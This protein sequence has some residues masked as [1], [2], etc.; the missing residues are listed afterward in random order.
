MTNIE[1][2]TALHELY[3]CVSHDANPAL[4]NP[5]WVERA[6]TAIEMATA[7]LEKQTTIAVYDEEELHHGCTVQVL[8][9]ST[10][11]EC[12]VGWWREE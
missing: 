12:S 1:A 6:Q 7:A 4:D 11:G 5:K 2:A 3:R 9:N 8:R 10:T